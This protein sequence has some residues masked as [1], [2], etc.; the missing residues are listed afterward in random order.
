MLK[1][2]QDR[3]QKLPEAWKH[4]KISMSDLSDREE[5]L[6]YRDRF[7][8]P[9]CEPLRTGLMQETHN[10][11]TTGHPGKEGMSRII[12]R[13]DFWPRMSNDIKRFVHNY[14]SC[15]RNTV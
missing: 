1:A 6:L 9:D 5:H 10:S 7:W 11:L 13:Q 2:V 3:L 4:L 15:G 8:V 12:S 14:Y